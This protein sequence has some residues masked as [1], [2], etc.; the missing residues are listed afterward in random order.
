MDLFTSGN[1][2]TLIIS[3][4]LVILFRQLDKNNRSIEKVKKFGD[5]LKAELEVFIKE[6]AS[7]LQES[8]IGLEVQQNKA[9]AAV[10]RLE[11][12][13]EDLVRKETELMERTKNIANIGKHIETYDATIK[14]LLEMTALAETNLSRIA[15]ESDF[16]DSLGK[17]LMASQKQLA[18]ISAVLPSLQESFT[19]ENRANL[20]AAHA[21]TLA[22]MAKT[23]ADLEHR[24]AGI[25]GWKRNM[26]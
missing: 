20:E 15:A 26:A 10:K 13:R 18:E 19:K 3:L 21:D 9:V 7:L 2:V 24:G 14:Q 5:K 17:K 11:S 6:K 16:A 25:L 8:S 4:L 12:I 23:I 22:K 1:I